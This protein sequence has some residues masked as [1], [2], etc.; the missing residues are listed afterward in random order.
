MNAQEFW[1]VDNV[2][3][4]RGYTV[5][6]GEIDLTDREYGDV[7]DDE[8]GDVNVGGLTFSTSDVIE[9]CD[10]VAWRCG[11]A[12]YESHLLSE[13]ERQLDREDDS[14]IEFID[15]LDDE[16]IDDEDEEE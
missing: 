2:S 14:D 5:S 16:D 8:Y 11:K 3:E 7:L 4:F 1:S 15:E 13:L 6:N 10:P 12:D 9:N